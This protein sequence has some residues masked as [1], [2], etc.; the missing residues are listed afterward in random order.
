MLELILWLAGLGVLLVGGLLTII[1]YFLK[2][3]SRGLR[4][5]L[6]G[7]KDDFK[8]LKDALVELS[9]RSIRNEE[10]GRGGYRELSTRLDHHEKRIEKLEDR[11]TKK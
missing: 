6:A 8:E 4:D 5:D 3:F 2:G 1:G 7:I 10:K 9:E 11:I